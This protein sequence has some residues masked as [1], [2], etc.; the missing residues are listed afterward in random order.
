MFPAGVPGIITRYATLRSGVRLRIA[1]AGAGNA[2]VILLLHGWGASVYM[3][4][5]WFAPLAAAG[6][7]VVAVDLPG[8]G[9]SDKPQSAAAYRLAPLM[10]VVRELLDVER[11]PTVDVVAQSMA[12]TIA[13]ELALAGEPRIGRLSLVSPA[14]FG[15]IPLLR[16]TPLL[17]SGLVGRAMPYLLTRGSVAR[18]HRLVY[19]DPTRITEA[20]IDQY[21]AP[22]QF[23][24]YSRALWR[25]AIGFEWGRQPADQMARRLRS[26]REPVRVVL[27]GRDR[28]VCDS[29]PYVGALAAAGAPVEVSVID[30]G[31]H[32]VNEEL[33]RE[34]LDLVTQAR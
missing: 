14:C 11:L 10:Q 18:A 9:L 19:G 23:P 1:E 21:W 28:L 6:W 15:R 25:L 30:A 22:S 16:V 32:A 5:A 20:D 17:R 4:R 26:L 8:H 27:G 31:G 34:V 7:H 33:P 3:W 29:R 24:A 12:G 2:P 13:L